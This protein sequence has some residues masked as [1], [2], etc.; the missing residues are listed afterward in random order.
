MYIVPQ[1][2]ASSGI[3]LAYSRG[4]AV[5]PR[6]TACSALYRVAAIAAALLL[7]ITAF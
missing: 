4:S 3:H 2:T 1:P 5:A 7:V 6:P